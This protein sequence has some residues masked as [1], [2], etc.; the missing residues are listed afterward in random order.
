MLELNSK[1]AIHIA[2][3]P[4]NKPL[5]NRVTLKFDEQC[6]V[7]VKGKKFLCVWFQEELSWTPLVKHLKSELARTIGCLYKVAHIILLWLKQLL[8]N[9]LF[10]SKLIYGIIMRGTTTKGNY[11]KLI[12][13]QK[14]IFHCYENIIDI[15]SSYEP[16]LCS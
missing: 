7:S 14:K 8:Y 10:Y 13:L 5:H 4:V 6:L 9:S 2:F 12:I 15:T 3:P 16:L 1:K 11:T